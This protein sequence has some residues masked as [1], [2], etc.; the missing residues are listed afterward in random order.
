MFSKSSSFGRR[1]QCVCVSKYKGSHSTSRSSRI[2]HNTRTANPSISLL[3]FPTFRPTFFFLLARIHETWGTIAIGFVGAI[4][5]RAQ[6]FEFAVVLCEE[7][8][9]LSRLV[10]MPPCRKSPSS[11]PVLYFAGHSLFPFRFFSPF[12]RNIGT[13]DRLRFA[14]VRV[15]V[16]VCV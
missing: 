2:L 5:V 9:F 10:T 13:S 7:N 3:F 16:C 15:C 14:Y 12:R 1:R 6:Y 8:F 11:K 4:F